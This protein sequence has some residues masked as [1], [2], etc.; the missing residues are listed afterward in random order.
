MASE[1]NENVLAPEESEL[2]EN[3]RQ[4]PSRVE[5][6]TPADTITGEVLV[7]GLA[8]EDRRLEERRH[9]AAE[10]QREYRARMH[11]SAREVTLTSN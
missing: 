3:G 2:A 11:K 5:S 8:N 10:R 6:V 7:D 1:N 9:T 4:V